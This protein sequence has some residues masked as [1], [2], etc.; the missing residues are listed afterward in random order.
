MNIHALLKSIDIEEI[1]NEPHTTVTQIAYDSRR[2]EPGTLFVCIKGF[3]VDGHK[4]AGQAVEK[5]AVAIVVEEI[6]EDIDVPQI[7]VSDTRIALAALADEFYDHPSQKIKTIGITATNGKTS[8]SFMTNAILENHGY[9]T[10]LMGTI[11][12]KIGDY[13]EPSELTTPESLDLHH[14]FK[15][16]VD[17]E[18][19]HATME[20]S[21]SAL[22]LNRIGNVDFDIVTLNNISREH[23]DLH[24][25]F[26]NYLAH[27]TG[28]VRNAGEGKIA[29]L[30]LDDPYSADLVD[31][32]AADVVTI[33]VERQDA[34]IRCQSLDLSTGRANFVV[35]IVRDIHAGGEVIPKQQFEINLATPGFHSV[36]NS[37][38]SIALGL[39]SGVSVE[40]IQQSLAEFVGVE[41]RFEIIFEEDFKIIDD[42]FANSGNI[43]VTLGTLVKMDFNK[44]KLVYAIRG[45][46]GVTVNRE[47]AE[48]IVKWASKLGLTE[49]VATCS[50]SHVTEKDVVRDNELDVFLAVMEEAGIRVNLFDELP[51]AIQEGLLNVEDEDIL[52]L[53]G[54]QGMDFGAKLALEQLKGL[55]PELDDEKLLHPLKKRVAG[56]V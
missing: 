11:V 23:I 50:R 48:T 51:D 33:G 39:L 38:V 36:Y 25:S 19:S 37:M 45:D 15:K 14:F 34:D 10:G 24:A 17:E 54:C 42:H 8:T 31:Q 21:S 47:N 56:N 4:F 6:L 28:L 35:E 46:R 26:E 7:R 16:M 30:N 29:I 2:V 12:V 20:V 49:V 5:G 53:A 27:K 3:K 43:D 13:A 1:K 40:T 22:E 9:K 41:R 44:V 32:T 52:L 18:V 55:R